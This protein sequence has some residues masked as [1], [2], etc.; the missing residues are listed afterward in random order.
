MAIEKNKI[1]AKQFEK[2]LK[3]PVLFQVGYLGIEPHKKQQGILK[4]ISK[5]KVICCGRRTG[6]THMIAG[7]IIRGATFKFY[8]RQ[9][10]VAPTYKQSR[11]VYNKILEILR[12]APVPAMNDLKKFT[13]HPHPRIEWINGCSVEFGSGDNPDSLRG[14]AYDRMF[15]DESGFLKETA[16][17]AIRPMAFDKGAPIWQTSTP[18]GKNNFYNDFQR[19][20]KG[21]DGYES[22]HFTTFDNPYI[23]KEEVQ[24]EVDDYGK[25]HVYVRTEIFGE[26]IEDIDCYF[27][28]ELISACIDDYPMIPREAV[29]V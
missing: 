12:N 29:Y 8:P 24:K 26:F 9:F 20:R 2:E 10:V 22:F 5:H 7:E 4:S 18:W 28:Q 27:T 14:E 11:I 16:L 19:G 15:W 6:K 21:V 25:D 1:D 17:Q 23:S 3:D 13:E